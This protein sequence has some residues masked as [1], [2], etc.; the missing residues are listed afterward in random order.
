MTCLA[1]TLVNMLHERGY[2]VK[3]RTQALAAAPGTERVVRSRFLGMNVTANGNQGMFGDTTNYVRV[4]RDGQSGFAIGSAT[5]DYITR[6]HSKY[7]PYPGDKLVNIVLGGGG[8][9]ISE[10]IDDVV[11]GWTLIAL[12]ICLALTAT[13][14]QRCIS[15][16]RLKKFHCSAKNL[17]Q[18]SMIFALF[19]VS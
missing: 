18:E 10:K 12:I 14:G 11:Y 4:D 3:P 15:L 8:L 2:R 9:E 6:V 7:N 17:K 5:Q 19:I 13:T 1:L 16:L